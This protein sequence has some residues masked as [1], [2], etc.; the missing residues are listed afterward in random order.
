MIFYYS[1]N[2]IR[3]L[4]RLCDFY[5]SENAELLEKSQM[6]DLLLRQF[7]EREGQLVRLLTPM[8]YLVTGAKPLA[9]FATP[10]E[11]EATKSESLVDISPVGPLVNTEPHHVY[12]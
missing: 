8:G 4:F 11:V 1:Q 2:L 5:S 12:R 9:P 3:G 7:V 10:E 6:E